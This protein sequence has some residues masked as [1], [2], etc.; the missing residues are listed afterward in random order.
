MG[1]AA[2]RVAGRSR[3]WLKRALLTLGALVLVIGAGV[4][5]FVATFDPRDYQDYIVRAV[6]EKTGRTLRIGGEMSLSVWPDVAVRL[7]D[8][9]LSER[10]SD[11]PFLHVDNARVTLAIVPLLSREIVAS[12][13]VLTNAKG[14]VT[15]YAD[16]RLNI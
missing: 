15:R 7:G 1:E 8:V 2:E 6:R 3:R 5:Y 16:G 10:G 12:E 11:E 14:V 9:S 4:T 13:L